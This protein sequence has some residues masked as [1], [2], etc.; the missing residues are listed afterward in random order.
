MG[1][2]A[3]HIDFQEGCGASTK[4]STHVCTETGGREYG[5]KIKDNVEKCP[6]STMCSR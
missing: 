1:D 5:Q 4:T 2:N 3:V 6:S